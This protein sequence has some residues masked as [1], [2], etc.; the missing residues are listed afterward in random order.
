M[1]RL[2]HQ[3]GS[4]RSHH[5]QIGRARQFDVP[6][7]GFIGQR[8]Q[9]LVNLVARQTGQRERG[10]KFAARSGQNDPNRTTLFFDQPDQ[11]E[12]FISRDTAADH[13]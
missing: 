7:R 5:D 13:Q 12:A 11:F 3:I 8:E 4:G 6:H 1:G 2:G 9:I 10:H